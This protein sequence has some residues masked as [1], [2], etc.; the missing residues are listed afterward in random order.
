[1][2]ALVEAQIRDERESQ[3][4]QTSNA[5]ARDYKIKYQDP[6]QEMIN[7]SDDEDLVTAYDIAQK[8]LN[9]N[10]RFLVEFKKPSTT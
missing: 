5:N 6:D 9:G 1:L 10:L 7:V 3:Q 4:I 2:K 8:E